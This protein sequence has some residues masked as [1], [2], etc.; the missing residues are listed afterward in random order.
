MNEAGASAIRGRNPFVRIRNLHDRDER[1]HLFFHHKRVIG[2]RLAEKQIRTSR[3]R[4]AGR[5]R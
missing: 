4:N 5:S 3:N 2:L 1:H